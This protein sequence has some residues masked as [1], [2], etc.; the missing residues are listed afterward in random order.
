[1]RVQVTPQQLRA[2]PGQP[3]F[4]SVTVS[5]TG[6]VIAGYS[7]RV[8]GADPGWVEV[9]DAEISVFPDGSQTVLV[10]ITV[11]E[12]LAAGPRRMAIGV[13]ELTP[14]NATVVE[15]IDIDVPA[16]PALDVSLDPVTINGARKGNASIV[17]QNQGNTV[18]SGRLEGNDP[19]EQ[20]RFH[21]EP[22]WI[23]LAPGEQITSSLSLRARRRMFGSPSI[24]PFE[25]RFDHVDAFT[26]WKQT[27]AGNSDTGE[28]TVLVP[29]DDAKPSAFVV[30]PI[31]NGTFLQRAFIARGAL[32]LLGL[33]LAV[34]VFALV[35][36]IAFSRVINQSAADR[37][38]AI[39]IAAQRDAGAGTG[40]SSVSGNV[41]QLTSGKGVADVAAQIYLA[42]DT[43]TAIATTAT[44]ATG[45]YHFTALAAGSYKISFLG[46]G[47]AQLW[48][49]AALTDADA[50]I[51]TLT[52]GQDKSGLDVLLGGIP[53]SIA[54]KII[55][56]D[57][58]GAT[59]KIALP[60]DSSAAG[61]V[62]TTDPTGGAAV[63]RTV[64]V[65]SDGTFTIESIPSPS[66][67]DLVVSKEGYATTIQ[68]VDLTGGEKRTGVEITLQ[69]GDGL[70]SGY[71]NGPAGR[72]G[73]ATIS[74]TSGATTIRTVSVTD[75]DT[76]AFSLRN[77]PTP[78]I[79]TVVVSQTGFSSS[80][81]TYSLTAA[82]K[83]TNIS[84]TLGTSAGSLSGK[85]TT[86]P[87][88][89]PA[90]GVVVTVSN[91]SRTVQTVTQSTGDVGSWTVGGLAIPSNYTVSFTRADLTST[92]VAVALDG[93]GNA[94]GGGS[95]TQVNATMKSSTAIVIG[96]A[97]QKAPSPSTA[98]NPVGEVTV[99]LAGTVTYTVTTA[100]LPAG[101]IGQYQ[102]SGVQPGT[103]TVSVNRKGTAATSQILILTAGQVYNYDP[104]LE[105][106]A[107]IT[108]I[109]RDNT[110]A[111]NPVVGT[112]VVL[113]PLASYPNV[114]V[115]VV[116]TDATGRYTFA[117]IDAPQSYVIEV[118]ASPSSPPLTSVTNYLQASQAL[119]Q[120]ITL[121]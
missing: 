10:S 28:S 7:L 30:E 27:T 46:A 29:V 64:P 76:G 93:F 114:P 35:I 86:L 88:N 21:F 63:V 111:H 78:A 70:I 79:V 4:V 38:L 2:M 52:A 91:G 72:L 115:A 118:R 100:S 99:T 45:A 41:R 105:A 113:Y 31:A 68:R 18:L 13:R 74:A 98:I 39:A 67:Y 15:E 3:A 94:T 11:P 59:V 8:L 84:V 85:V 61:T 110:P 32:S 92:T 44:D 66:I 58:S 57:V 55:G 43:S 17:L 1:M 23:K 65:G 47:F 112:Q 42:A 90:S 14:P 25:I 48:Y 26:S 81:A 73:G 83:L 82:Q 36:T 53:A 108:G 119:T 101:Q 97:S 34:S 37:E 6:E 87:G 19:E 106:P 12:G 116:T 103:Y 60:I 49:P 40:T 102:L 20:L 96:K 107:S 89:V 24:R 71:V 16:A 62:S 75:G 120:D 50:Q 104:I 77:L 95:A 54:G 69:K 80:T 5:N 51:L 56:T 121:P 117:D 9:G 109:V 33:L 22:P